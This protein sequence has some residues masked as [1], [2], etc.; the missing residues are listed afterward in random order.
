MNCRK[1]KKVKTTASGEVKKHYLW[2]EMLV[3][4]TS[5]RNILKEQWK[6]W[7]S[8]KN[9]PE[10]WKFCDFLG[11]RLFK[12]Y[13][14]LTSGTQSRVRVMGETEYYGTQGVPGKVIS[15]V[16]G[17]GKTKEWVLVGSLKA[18]TP[19]FFGL[20]TEEAE[21]IKEIEHTSLRLVMDK[22]GRYRIPRT[23]LRGALRRDLRIA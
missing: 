18:E 11:E 14:R 17:I 2:D 23:V 13:K 16:R 10:W 20:E 21:K 1:G 4:D 5:V 3:N 19:F 9:D 6:Q 15:L 22:K 7:Q 8:K 12:E